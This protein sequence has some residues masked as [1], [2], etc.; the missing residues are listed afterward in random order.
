M[1]RSE[2][3]SVFFTKYLTQPAVDTRQIFEE[4]LKATL[5]LCT[6]HNFQA[7]KNYCSD[8]CDQAEIKQ[9][10]AFQKILLSYILYFLLNVQDSYPL[11]IQKHKCF[12]KIYEI[13]QVNY[14]HS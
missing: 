4:K 8:Y 7:G 3:T 6:K 14:L 9:S 10:M 1:V 2:F 13:F 11:S 12:I 5:G